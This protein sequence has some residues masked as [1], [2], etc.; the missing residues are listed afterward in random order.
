MSGTMLKAG[1]HTLELPEEYKLM[2]NRNE[3]FAFGIYIKNDD[4]EDPD[5]KWDMAVEMNDRGNPSVNHGANAIIGNRET[6][7][8][9]FGEI[10]DLKMLEAGTGKGINACIKVYCK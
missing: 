9:S 3:V 2:L 10:N 4:T 6:Y 1:Y 8:I 5:H 7:T